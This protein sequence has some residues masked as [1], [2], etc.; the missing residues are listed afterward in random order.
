MDLVDLVP[1]L[2]RAVSGPGEFDTNFPESDT[3]S[4][5]GLLADAVSE[6]Q[7]DGFLSTHTLDTGTNAVDPDLVPALQ[8]LVILYGM[9]RVT[10]ARIAN[11]RNHT[12]YKAGNV[13]AEVEQSA[14]VL[15][16]LLKDVNARKKQLLED[17]R[18]GNLAD[19]FLMVD[20]YVAK[21]IDDYSGVSLGYATPSWY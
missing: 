21:S 5:I 1:S 18:A 19:A 15:V 20:M 6:A 11:L 16:Q 10:T 4:L 3:A 2:K 17:A 9:A 14:T 13:E 12:R 8:A 7:L